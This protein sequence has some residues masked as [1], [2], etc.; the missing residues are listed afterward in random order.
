MIRSLTKG[1]GGVHI[2]PRRHLLSY[3]LCRVPGAAGGEQMVRPRS[4]KQADIVRA[5]RSARDAGVPVARVKVTCKDG[6]II[7]VLGP[8]AA[9]TGNELDKW[10]KGKD[11][12]ARQT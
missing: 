1:A 2:V 3:M 4:F 11:K 6:V 5:I 12:D 10:L 7:E 8:D 9:A